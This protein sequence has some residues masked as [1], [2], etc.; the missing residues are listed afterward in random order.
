M[1]VELEGK[2]LYGWDHNETACNYG[3]DGQTHASQVMAASTDYGLT[4]KIAGPHH[5]GHRSACQDGKETGDSCG[6]V[7]RG[8]DG[9][10]YAYCVHNGGSLLG[11]R[12]RLHPRVRRR[13]TRVRASGR[14]TTTA[15]GQSR[16]SVANRA[17]LMEAALHGGTQPM[18][19]SASIGSKAAWAWSPRATAFTLRPFSRSRSC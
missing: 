14:S 3:S 18:K 7:V 5:P 10:D 15:H 13:R 11:R 4:W 17:R 8:N 6:N 12:L 16:E 9:Y 1:H 19:P 2:T